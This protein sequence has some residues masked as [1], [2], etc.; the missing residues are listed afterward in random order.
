MLPR[1]GGK[2]G[3][4]KTPVGSR[5]NSAASATGPTGKYARSNPPRSAGVEVTDSESDLDESTDEELLQAQRSRSAA[6]IHRSSAEDLNKS[7]GTPSRGTPASA[8]KQRGVDRAVVR[9]TAR[10]V[11]TQQ[12]VFDM[13]R[14]GAAEV[15]DS[16]GDESDG[17][18]E[19]RRYMQHAQL[20]RESSR[21]PPSAEYEGGTVRSKYGVKV[22]PINHERPPHPG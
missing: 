1:I 8:Q 9:E 14:K 20:Q 16:T 2:A 11:T 6:L 4:P 3:T 7:R 10:P 5:G 18:A 12:Q 21:A 13:S 22:R 19:G 15:S 17:D